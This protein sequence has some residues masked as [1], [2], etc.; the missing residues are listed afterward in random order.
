[1]L[2][3]CV[4][5]SQ[6]VFFSSS[7]HQLENCL[8]ATRILKKILFEFPKSVS[9]EADGAMRHR[10]RILS[11]KLVRATAREAVRGVRDSSAT[12]LLLIMISILTSGESL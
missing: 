2:Q 11:G 10:R 9:L 1:M 7:L 5:L 12:I 8:F 3:Q 6:F 4:K